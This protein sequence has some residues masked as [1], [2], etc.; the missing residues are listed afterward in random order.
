MKMKTRFKTY[1]T[2]ISLAVIASSALFYSCS[3]D[4]YDFNSI[5]PVILNVTGPAQVAGHGVATSPYTYRVPPR[6]GSTFAWTLDPTKWGGTITVDPNRQYIAKIVFNQSDTDTI[7]KIRVVETTLGGK[8]SPVKEYTVVIKPFCPFDIDNFIGM[9]ECDEPGY[10]VYNVEF[11]AVNDS[12]IIADNFWDSGWDVQY[13]FHK[14]L[15]ETVTIIPWS[16]TTGSGV[17]YE[18]TGSG[19]YNG[20]DG[21]FVVNYVVKRN[22]AD[23]DVNTHTYTRQV[24]SNTAP[25][26]KERLER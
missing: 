3:E 11:T 15:S 22:G 14:D 4:E 9:Y 13:K 26:K 1:L 7:A 5:E 19:K 16:W 20:C 6:G 21:S 17:L 25:K 18:V 24:K 2:F 23:Y 10:A 12:I 8:V